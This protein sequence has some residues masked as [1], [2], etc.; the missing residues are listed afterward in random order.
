MI[1]IRESQPHMVVKL[2]ESVHVIAIADIRAL[3]NG[4][5]YLGEKDDIIQVLA[6]A[7]VDNLGD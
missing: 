6:R 1:N 3:A 7:L 4:E 5:K 2:P